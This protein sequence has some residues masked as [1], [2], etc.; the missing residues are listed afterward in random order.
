MMAM[1]MM[2]AESMLIPDESDCSE[3]E[4]AFNTMK[5][6][7]IG[8]AVACYVLSALL[9][10]AFILILTLTVFL[11]CMYGRGNIINNS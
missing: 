4:N 1:L 8:L 5:T 10:V 11:V 2:G 7:A 9:F 3:A 6:I